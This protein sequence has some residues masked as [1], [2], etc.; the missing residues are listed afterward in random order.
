MLRIF[1]EK[2]DNIM[3]ELY[4]QRRMGIEWNWECENLAIPRVPGGSPFPNVIYEDFKRLPITHMG[5]DFH[6]PDL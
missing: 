3:N 4:E 1:Q 2:L 6:G 5:F